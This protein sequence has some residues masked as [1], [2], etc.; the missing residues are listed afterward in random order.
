MK[1]I[2]GLKDLR[3]N[4]ETWISQVGKGKSFVVIRKSKPVFNIT[5]VDEWGD[6]GTW[7]TVVDF[8]DKKGKGVPAEDLLKM[9]KKLNTHE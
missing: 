4:M 1:N 8:R 3:D 6:E 9:L 7:E 2:I 5:P